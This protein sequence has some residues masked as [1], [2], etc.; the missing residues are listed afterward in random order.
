M[1][2]LKQR[3]NTRL[4][5]RLVTQ[6]NNNDC[7]S[8]ISVRYEINIDILEI[9]LLSSVLTRPPLMALMEQ[10]ITVAPHQNSWTRASSLCAYSFSKTKP[11]PMARSTR[12]PHRSTGSRALFSFGRSPPASRAPGQRSGVGWPP[13]GGSTWSEEW[14]GRII[15]KSTSSII[16][17]QR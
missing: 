1:I 2:I 10:S 8:I 16:S 14:G 7:T 9:V 3:K 11:P 12:K 13:V 5:Q 15:K 6:D 17:S 4:S